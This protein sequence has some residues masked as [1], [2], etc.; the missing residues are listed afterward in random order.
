MNTALLIGGPS[1]DGGEMRLE[2]R[3][4]AT[5]VAVS[6]RLLFQ[7]G[8]EQGPYYERGVRRLSIA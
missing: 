5:T 6:R 7:G 3:D 1:L 8:S 4:V 2:R